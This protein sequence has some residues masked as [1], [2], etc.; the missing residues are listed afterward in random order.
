VYIS[1]LTPNVTASQSHCHCHLASRGLRQSIA[2]M[3]DKDDSDAILTTSMLLNT[4]CYCAADYRD[5]ELHSPDGSHRPRWDWFRIQIGITD[6]LIRTK[7][8]HPESIWLFLLARPPNFHLDILRDSNL[9]AQL[10]DFCGLGE[11]SCADNNVYFEPIRLLT[12]VVERPP[13]VELS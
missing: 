3:V 8:F 9:G 6:L 7:P 1:T 4:L 11:D 10:A 2:S 5:E 13:S 12:P